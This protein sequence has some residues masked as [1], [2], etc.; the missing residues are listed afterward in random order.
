MPELPPLP[1]GDPEALARAA[2]A[3]RPSVAE[4]AARLEAARAALRLEKAFRIPEPSLT[5]GYKR[6]GGLDTAVAGLSFPLPLFD[7]NATGVARAEAE[8][9]AA[10]AAWRAASL[11]AAAEVAATLRAARTFAGRARAAETD[12]LASAVGARAAA[13]ASFREGVSEVLPLVDAERVT[14]EAVR[15]T[16]DLAVDARLASLAARLALG[17]EVLP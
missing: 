11:G 16:L 7:T 4:A 13:R 8:A 12:L 6:T 15:E 2:A 10:E 3:S 14:A 9:R 17:Q 5:A 1:E